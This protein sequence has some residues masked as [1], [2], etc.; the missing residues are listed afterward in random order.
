MYIIHGISGFC[1]CRQ[2]FI[3]TTILKILK[4]TTQGYMFLLL[5]FLDFGHAFLALSDD[6][7]LFW[8]EL[9]RVQPGGRADRCAKPTFLG[10][11]EEPGAA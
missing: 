9:E 3:T 6:P 2:S 11:R 10:R 8:P 5:F 1:C 4:R 7:A